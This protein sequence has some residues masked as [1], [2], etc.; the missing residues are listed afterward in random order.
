MGYDHQVIDAK[1]PAAATLNDAFSAAWWAPTSN[2]LKYEDVE[3][4]SASPEG[5]SF[6]M[7]RANDGKVSMTV[8]WLDLAVEHMSK[9]WK[10]IY[11]DGNGN[12]VELEQS[13][14]RV[15]DIFQKYVKSRQ[16]ITSTTN[17]ES[18]VGITLDMMEVPQSTLAA[19]AYMPF[20]STIDPKNLT[21]WSL[22][23]TISSLVQFGIGRIVVSGR[24]IEEKEL[25]VEAFGIVNDHFRD[26]KQQHKQFDTAHS[27]E[28][29]VN[30]P[31]GTMSIQDTQLS[32]CLS[33]NEPTGDKWSPYNIP[34]AMLKKLRRVLMGDATNDEIECWLGG[35]TINTPETNSNS[36][37]NGSPIESVAK[38]RWEYIFLGEPDLLLTTRRSSLAAIGE[39]LKQGYVLS[40]HRLQP[41][42]HGSDFPGL[43]VENNVKHV[44][45]AVE[46]VS[47][48]RKMPCI[49]T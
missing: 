5:A 7:F 15:V 22:A 11:N 28:H 36:K 31:H 3:I 2:F 45:P 43:L 18:N 17:G 41:L 39:Q 12:R 32:F 6:E 9:W 37:N 47:P 46:Q 8:D 25:V 44:V 49:A 23:A 21:V 35:G 26:H 29:R 19:I 38:S 42:P 30:M 1:H 27:T 4:V 14:K 24:L 33:M 20:S 16:P 10:V 13:S 34:K 48:P 40:P